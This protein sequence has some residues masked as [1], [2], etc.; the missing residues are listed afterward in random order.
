MPDS[1]HLGPPVNDSRRWL[2]A[3]TTSGS[4]PSDAAVLTC[5]IAYLQFAGACLA[6][7]WLVVPPVGDVNR[8]A[9]IVVALS[10][11]VFAVALLRAAVRVR[12]SWLA[13]IALFSTAL[14]GA[15]T[16]LAGEAATPFSLLYLAAAG[17]AIWCFS[18]RQA[19][20]QV[21]WIAVAFGLGTWIYRSPGDPS[22]PQLSSDD[23]KSLLFWGGA[24]GAVA[25]LI[26]MFKRI[27]VDRDQR[28]AAVVDSSQDAIFGKDREGLIT[29]WNRGAERLYGYP[30]SEAIG[31]P[32]G[33]LV[34]PSH[35]GEAHELLR[36]VLGA[37]E[38]IERYR[39]ERVCK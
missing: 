8:P 39:T 31:Q 4:R 5:V 6:V 38:R 2:S 30:A 12:S 33:L 16:S 19:I 28:L 27:V 14:L 25:L 13:P 37:D 29:V 3:A 17:A 26:K 34:P 18:S 24:L 36:R 20:V 35:A 21:G 22:W 9:L 1:Q 15:Y 7:M 32:V 10:G 11:A 23:L